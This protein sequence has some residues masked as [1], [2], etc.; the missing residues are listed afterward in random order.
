MAQET[1]SGEPRA[2]GEAAVGYASAYPTEWR[3]VRASGDM[4]KHNLRSC[5]AEGHGHG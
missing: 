4:L 2:E 5:C 1:R 3:A